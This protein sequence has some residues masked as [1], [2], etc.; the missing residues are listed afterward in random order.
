MCA[1][2]PA[3][4]SVQIRCPFQRANGIAQGS[5]QLAKYNA[6]RDEEATVRKESSPHSQ[7]H[8]VLLD[9]LGLCRR[10]KSSPSHIHHSPAASVGSTGLQLSVACPYTSYT[11][12]CPSPRIRLHSAHS[13]P[14]RYSRATPVSND[15]PARWLELTACSAPSDKVWPS[16]APAHRRAREKDCYWQYPHGSRRITLLT[17]LTRSTSSASIKRTWR[18]C[19]AN[20]LRSHS[21]VA[22]AASS[23]C[24]ARP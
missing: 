14:G 7:R 5:V 1:S 12:A 18:V 15:P 10:S 4:R 24:R 11:A 23:L 22:A 2:G 13:P 9:V 20:R 16:L 8:D 17:R 19:P 3:P 6:S 21:R